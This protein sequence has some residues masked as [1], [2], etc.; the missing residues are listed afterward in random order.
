VT[1]MVDGAG[2]AL[3]IARQ[4]N[5]RI[6]AIG[7]P[8]RNVVMSYGANGFVSEVRDSANRVMRYTYT[9]DNRLE[10]VTDA[11]AKVTRYSY[12]DDTEIAQD[13]VCGVQPT[14]GQ[15]LKT[16]LY[17]GRPLPT[18]NFHGSS[19][20]VL[21]QMGYDGREFKFAY[22]V[23]GAC[24]TRAANPGVKCTA[25]CPDL[26]S[27]ENFQAGWR[28]HGGRVIAT[29]VV[30]PDGN[31]YTHSFNVKGWPQ[32]SVDANGQTSRFKYDAANRPIER[33]DALSR[34]WKYQ[35][36]QRGNLVQALDPLNR[37]TAM[38]YDGKWNKVTN[39]VR[40]LPDGT[41]V[42]SQAAY[43]PN[44][45]NAVRSI[46]PLG[47]TTTF[48]YTPR[49]QLSA[50]T[51]PGNRTVS[52]TYNAAGDVIRA[53]D[54]L[55][56]DTLRE[57]DGAGRPIKVTDPLG[58][59]TRAEYNGVDQVTKVVDP[60][61]QETR[62]SY[63]PAQ[64]LASVVDPR[65]N[66]VETRQ[67][68][69]GDRLTARV[70]ALNKAAAYRYDGAGRPTQFTDR[71]GQVTRYAYDAQSRITRIDY[72]DTTQTRSYDLVGRLTDIREPGSVITY[73]YDSV[74]RLVSAIT[75]SAAGRHEVG[76][77]YDTL[78]RLTRR[79]LNGADPTLYTYDKADR[80]AAISYRNQ[81]TAYTWDA[82]SR[83]SAK[84]LP[85]GIQQEFVYDDADRLLSIAYKKTDGT[86]IETISYTYDAKGQR[87]SKTS[88]SASVRETA[89]SATYDPANRLATLTLAGTGETFTL[90]YDDNGNLA[91]KQGAASG[92]TTYT[93]D[94]RNRL[95]QITSPTTTA[96][97]QYDGL[98]RRVARTVNGSTTQYVYDGPQAI[99]EITNGQAAALLTGLQIDEV[100]ARYT[101]AGTRTYLTDALG[102]VI[103]QTNDQQ[104]V[105]NFYGYTPYG[106]TQALGPDEGNAI[107]YT[108]RENDQTGLYYYRARYYDPV[109]K[110][111]VSEDPIGLGG[112]TN[113]YAYVRGNP[114][115]YT[116]SEGLQGT[117][118]FGQ[119]PKPQPPGPNITLP[120]K[121]T[122][123][124][125]ICVITS[126][127]VL[128][129]AGLILGKFPG[130][131]AGFVAGL[132]IGVLLCPADPP[133]PK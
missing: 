7:S 41:S 72:P 106:E 89:V 78:D 118:P 97:F 43:D 44:T 125:E 28:F 3:S 17:P 88:G 116:D 63:D 6:N 98:G 119:S 114:V 52:F 113:V 25:N 86:P 96:T 10:T 91:Q 49:G 20:R 81:T 90:T 19:R 31:T 27:W 32:Q 2:N 35:Y 26:D 128:G 11:D 105:Q 29:T 66:A 58:F 112:G 39:L 9:A 132:A 101:S 117:D 82:A 130:G 103:A 40:A 80:L 64:R 46:D 68:D 111:F 1:E 76:Y 34:T 50:V 104:A 18:E 129:G 53:T 60:L 33:S 121:E 74:D 16:M 122:S 42:V 22:K 99:G 94:S 4:P 61:L 57:T 51:V 21:R 56:N 120:P 14:A 83:L 67:Y 108:A 48:A 133:P 30:K 123:P 12:V 127:C 5:G 124:N 110:R 47:N 55:G 75:D 70:D 23:T 24:V 37:V 79:T 107:Q 73:A 126:A 8:E 45:G 131:A 54:P 87:L 92:T 93:W 71:K 13:A 115:S 109:L 85:N 36:D 38:T 100:I 95:T 59:D 77:E 102:S 84:V 62:Y 15:R 69:G 65:N